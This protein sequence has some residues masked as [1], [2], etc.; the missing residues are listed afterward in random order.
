MEENIFPS[1]QSMFSQKDIEEERRLL[2]VAITRAKKQIYMSYC[3]TRFRFNNYISNEP[4]RFI[5]EIDTA[6]IEKLQ[7]SSD[8]NH[9]MKKKI[10]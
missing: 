1:Q 5:N 2:Y 7:F 8:K 4:S 10:H 9:L 6:C 3:Q